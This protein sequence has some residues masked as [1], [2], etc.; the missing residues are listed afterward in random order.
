MK[1]IYYCCDHAKADTLLRLV[2]SSIGRSAGASSAPA[3]F[4]EFYVLRFSLKCQFRGV[5]LK[6]SLGFGFGFSLR[7]WG[8]AVLCVTSE[9]NST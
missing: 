4:Q 7:M 5:G 3:N 8:R 1:L 2:P 9:P 6:V